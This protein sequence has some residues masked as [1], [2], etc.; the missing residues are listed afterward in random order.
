MFNNLIFM[1]IVNGH[2]KVQH[3]KCGLV[4]ALNY[5]IGCMNFLVVYFSLQQILPKKKSLEHL[6]S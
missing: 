2:D 1:K 6:K 4:K 5:N 3:K